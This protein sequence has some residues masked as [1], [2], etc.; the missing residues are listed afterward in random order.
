M[1]DSRASFDEPATA[2]VALGLTREEAAIDPGRLAK[3]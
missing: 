1:I 2:L 3:S